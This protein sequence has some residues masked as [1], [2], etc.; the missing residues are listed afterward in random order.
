LSKEPLTNHDALI[1]LTAD[2]R[3]VRESL[4]E[5]KAVCKEIPPLKQMVVDHFDEHKR[6]DAEHGVIITVISS[7]IASIIA[8]FSR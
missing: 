1:N 5:I 7:I 2:M 4:D 3:Y 8:R 6:K